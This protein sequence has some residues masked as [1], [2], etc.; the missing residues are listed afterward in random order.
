M[1]TISY[2][3]VVDHSTDAGFRAWGSE[4]DTKMAAAGLVQTADTGQINWL[5]VTRPATNTSGGYTIWRL[6]NS[7]LYFKFEYGTDASATIPRMWIT[8]GT[9]SNGSGTL[10]G[11]LSTRNIWTR[12]AAITSTA[13]NY[14]TYICV[15][16]DAIS[17]LWKYAGFQ[18]G[19]NGGVLCI[20]R[21]TDSTGATDTT[22]Y[23]VLRLNTTSVTLQSVRTVATAATMT[24]S[25]YFST[26]VGAEANTV[27]DSG[28]KQI[29]LC[30][31]NTKTVRPFAWAICYST[32]D[33]SGTNTITVTP[34]GATSH[35]YIA[36]GTPA[37]GA[38][39]VAANYTFALIFE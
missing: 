10:T 2:S 8:V 21:T 12:G 1:T 38:A 33:A 4:L 34:F 26:S 24:E 5:T 3:S 18:T 22:G 25:Q 15:T 9:G 35:T 23:A 16:A 14:P 7:S 39:G 28:N 30:F 27:D 19:T 32:A 36:I 17:I 29:Y 6:A 11:Q 20:G 13:T 31:M 37:P